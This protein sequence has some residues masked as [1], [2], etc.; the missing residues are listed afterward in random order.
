MNLTNALPQILSFT[1]TLDP[2]MAA[3]FFI[4]CAIGE[5]GVS[6]PY[7]LEGVWLLAGYQLGAG[8][9]SP[10]HLIG[11]WLAA[12]CGRQVGAMA[13]YRVGRFGTKPLVGLYHK[14]HLTR[15]FSRVTAKSGA[16]NRINL[17]SPFSVAY[18]RLL[19]M[20]IPLALTLGVKKK[21][22]MLSMGVLISSI[23]WDA[24]YISLGIIF[25]STTAIK[26]VYMFFASLA[27]L[28]IIYL[29]TFIVRRVIRRLKP[30]SSS[31][32]RSP[33]TIT[34]D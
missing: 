27:G 14:L 4:L 19:G 33:V 24:A 34:E 18:G 32:S 5:F 12:Q 16:F 11:L 21:P 31:A 1:G 17:A 6:I 25:G 15:F 22:K 7:I 2:R 20:R 28:T 9:L 13:L 26:P 29:V 8:V 30:A 23:I 3:L 10:I